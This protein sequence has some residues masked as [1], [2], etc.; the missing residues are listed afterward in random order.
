MIE[1]HLV[2]ADAGT[3]DAQFRK[4]A[5][6]IDAGDIAAIERFLTVHPGLVGARL[7]GK[8]HHES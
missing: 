5:S 3:L 8:T 4:A 2:M 6:A 7:Q 1:E